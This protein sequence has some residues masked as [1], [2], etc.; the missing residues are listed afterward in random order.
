MWP[1]PCR[2]AGLASPVVDLWIL[3]QDVKDGVADEDL[4]PVVEEP[5]GRQ[6]RD[7]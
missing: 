2:T 1:P 4:L 5:D 7:R 3:R 6:G